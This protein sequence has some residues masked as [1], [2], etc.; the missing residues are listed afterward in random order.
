MKIE[1]QNEGAIIIHSSAVGTVT[2]KM[3]RERAVE[4]AMIDGRSAQEVSKSDWDVAK[5]ELTGGADL[6]PQQM[7][8]ESAP[9]SERWD[10]LPGS[11]GHEIPVTSIDGE[12]DD[13][14]SLG[15]KLID[16]GTREADHDQRLKSA[17]SDQAADEESK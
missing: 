15:E 17:R 7:A 4:L 16:E 11:T 8:L 1:P 9:E 14:K 3:V 5:R 13:G 2:R 12:D 6:D 10:P